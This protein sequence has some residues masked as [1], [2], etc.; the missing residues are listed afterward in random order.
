VLSLVFVFWR[1]ARVRVSRETVD[2]W[3]KYLRAESGASIFV[4]SLTPHRVMV[5]PSSSINYDETK[6][7]LLLL[8]SKDT[9]LH[10]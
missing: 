8:I 3:S 9:L 6:K 4:L 2:R 7:Q 5:E 10:P 1:P